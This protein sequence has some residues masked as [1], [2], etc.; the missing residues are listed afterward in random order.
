MQAK[1]VRIPPLEER[2]GGGEHSRR[3]G[4]HGV[5]GVH[6]HGPEVVV[7]PGV[8]T[9]DA[10][11]QV[12]LAR[13][14]IALKDP[15]QGDG[16]AAQ[17]DDLIAH[18]WKG[19]A[20]PELHPTLARSPQDHTSG[21]SFLPLDSAPAATLALVLQCHPH[22]LPRP[23]SAAA[24]PASAQLGALPSL[25]PRHPHETCQVLLL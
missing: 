11:L 8:A 21:L 4:R 22:S 2:R 10:A 18:L 19:S 13:N 14:D 23:C 25:W 15:V 12:L 7:F 5:L 6:L 3:E 24:L 20:Q 9:G 16:V 17:A 1:G